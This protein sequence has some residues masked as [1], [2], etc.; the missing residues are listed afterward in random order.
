[1]WW[2][3]VSRF[4]AFLSEAR[5]FTIVFKIA[6][7]STRPARLRSSTKDVNIGRVIG[8]AASDDYSKVEV[9]A[10]IR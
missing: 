7:G 5:L 8:G 3:S 10:K 2:P 4:S 1:V 6:E 9:T